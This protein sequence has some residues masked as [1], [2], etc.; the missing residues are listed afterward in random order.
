MKYNISNC[1]VAVTLSLISDKWKMLIIYKLMN[2][3]KHHGKIKKAL[4][5]ISQKV[6]T[7]NLKS[8]EL[9]SLILRV[10]YM[11][12]LLRVE[13]SLTN[14]GCSLLP[15]LYSMFECGTSYLQDMNN[16]NISLDFFNLI[17]FII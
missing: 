9:T 1:P 2:E 15:I 10:S 6:L 5:G 17:F 4:N 12:M 14:K 11:E 16:T 8:M 7:E 13:Y 3:P